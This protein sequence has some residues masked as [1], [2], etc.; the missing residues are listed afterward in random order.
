MDAA[1]AGSG[2]FGGT[3]P[4][5]VEMTYCARDNCGTHRILKTTMALVITDT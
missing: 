3:P 1:A 4:A 2:V 5:T